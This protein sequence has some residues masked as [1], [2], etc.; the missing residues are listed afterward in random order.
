MG[1]SQKGVCMIVLIY[2]VIGLGT[3]TYEARGG[4]TPGRRREW[5]MALQ[6]DILMQNKHAILQN[7]KHVDH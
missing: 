6:Q 7:I 3:I 1:E 4:E 2:N 5:R